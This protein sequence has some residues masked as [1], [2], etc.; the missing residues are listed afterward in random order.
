MGEGTGIVVE[1]RYR[2]TVDGTVLDLDEEGAHTLMDAL[3]QRLLPAIGAEPVETRVH[4]L[5]PL[6]AAPV[7][8]PVRAALPEPAP[9]PAVDDPRAQPRPPAKA[10]PG[11]WTDADT[12]RLR[13]LAAEGMDSKQIADAMGRK[14]AVIYYR[15]GKYKIALGLPKGRESGPAA[16]VPAPAVQA[17]AEDGPLTWTPARNFLLT[18]TIRD[19]GTFSD[20]A[21]VLK[22]PIA[23]VEGQHARLHRRD[24][25][26]PAGGHREG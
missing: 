5:A 12:D 25:N 15:A 20:A 22:V 16:A 19:G 21:R 10:P 7:A 3:A 18:R 13:T 4:V 23:E 11:E 2:V 24:G 1:T 17:G 9:P 8:V 26:V 6:P 14:P